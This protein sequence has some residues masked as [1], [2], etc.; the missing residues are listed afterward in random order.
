MRSVW[1]AAAALGSKSTAAPNHRGGY[2]WR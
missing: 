2:R 1:S